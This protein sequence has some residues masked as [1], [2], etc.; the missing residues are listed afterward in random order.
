M[1]EDHGI[2]GGRRRPRGVFGREDMAGPTTLSCDVVIVGSGAGGATAA[3]ELAEGGLDVIVIEEGGYHDTKS[4]TPNASEMI[5]K[6]YRDA[7]A[8]ASLGNPPV[9]FQEG[10]TVGGSTVI[11]GGMS[12]RTPEA[13]LDRWH[14][15]AGLHRVRPQEMDPFFARVEDRINV[16]YQDPE[17][18]GRDNALLKL[19][20]DRKG[21]EVIDNRRN[22]LHC[23]GT[24]NCF[25][26]S[27]RAWVL[28]DGHP[29]LATLGDLAEISQG[30]HPI[31]VLAGDGQSRKAVAS[32][33]GVQRLVTVSFAPLG[34]RS[35]FR[36]RYDVTQDHRWILE[37]GSETTGLIVGDRVKIETSLFRADA[38]DDDL[39]SGF[40]HGFV[41]GDGT[42]HTY[43]RDRF[44]V[45]LCADK[46][47]QYLE[48]L[49]R[50]QFHVS[51]TWPKTYGGDPVARFK[52]KPGMN[53]KALPGEDTSLAYQ[54]AFVRGWLVADGSLK[55]S[56]SIALC[57]QN[58]EAGSWLCERA[59]LLGY[60]V[61]GFNH[62]SVQETNF[63]PRSAPMIWISLTDTDTTFVV[64][65]ILQEGRQE[66][67]FCITEPVTG[68][69]ALEGGLV[70][71]NC[72]FGCP[73][74]AK[75][76]ALVTYVPRSLH[77][78]ARVYS[79]VRVDSITR[80]GK[81][82]TGVEGHVTLPG[83]RRGPSVRVHAKVVI[84]A[85]GSIQTPALLHRSGFK[86]PSG[87]LGRNLSMHPNAK[88]V[89]VFDEDVRGWEGVHQAYQVRQFQEEG[90]LMAAVNIPP[91]IL[92][93]TA[94]LYGGALGELMQDY[95]R[96]V[97]AG[98]LVE[99]STLGRVIT[100][101]SGKPV[102]V[103]QLNDKDAQQLVRGTRLLCE[104]LFGAGA[105]KIYL[106]FDGVD[107][108]YG[109][110]DI[111]RVLDRPI[112]KGGMEVVTVHMM[113]T[114]RMGADRATAVTDSY[115]NVYD[116]DRLLV[117]DAS[118]F[119]TPIGVNPCMTIQT[120]ATR[121][122]AHILNNRR[123]YLS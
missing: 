70:T 82:A 68:R 49:E 64:K 26:A 71:G 86:S 79:D 36:L 72:A 77:F 33:F 54:R 119:P 88:V 120:L 31:E 84:S 2:E 44:D 14:R 43:D 12:W 9:L 110:D 58:A 69:F 95:N 96:T 17:T 85:C 46:D 57:T 16:A 6:L 80:S 93:M 40:A 56:G 87:Q 107:T 65:S 38:R 63:G 7:G 41:F 66:E 45:R 102:A 118:L 5:S 28:R 113:G 60:C 76:S 24:N 105:R 62:D 53:W 111:A 103:Y 52:L 48:H 29:I 121:N 22:Q 30:E 81:R 109:P 104:L 108:L 73:V 78:G 35:N 32:S 55:P 59:P 34:L 3:A 39:A 83:G 4:F 99:D 13:I 116:A 92:A 115:G 1:M 51:T 101:P 75:R 10:R 98:I 89:A 114:A 122:A 67:V 15:E 21:W 50:S 23:A 19:G 20:A 123:R 61:T 25:S 97:I 8:S 106:P 100:T 74:G 37:D 94:P 90:F 117:C 112:A 18:I 47:K 11:N 91:S 27:T 42:R